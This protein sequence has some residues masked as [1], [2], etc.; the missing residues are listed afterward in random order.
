MQHGEAALEA[1]EKHQPQL[2]FLDVEM[3]GM[4]GFQMLEACVKPAF[5]VIF[6]TAYNQYAIP[7]IRHSALDYLL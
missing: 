4:D 7:A 1:I 5:E 6:T 3:P 2:L